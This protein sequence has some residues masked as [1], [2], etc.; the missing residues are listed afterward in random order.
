MS[1]ASRPAASSRVRYPGGAGY[2]G[3]GSGRGCVSVPWRC[4]VRGRRGG[5]RR[6][7]FSSAYLGLVYGSAGEIPWGCRV[8]R[9]WPR[10]PGSAVL[11]W[12]VVRVDV[13]RGRARH[14]D[15][16]L[17][18]KTGQGDGRRARAEPREYSTFT[19][20]FQGIVWGPGRVGRRRRGCRVSTRRV[21]GSELGGRPRRGQGAGAG[22]NRRG[23]TGAGGRCVG[24]AM[25]FLGTFGADAFGGCERIFR[26]GRSKVARFGKKV[27]GEAAAARGPH[28]QRRRT[29]EKGEGE[30]QSPDQSTISER[31]ALVLGARGSQASSLASRRA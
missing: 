7:E 13:G 28:K 14:Q 24:A 9:R 6:G 17:L 2:A 29:Y 3:T 22:K 11:V 8:P 1:R 4:R 12:C 31:T 20:A 21:P 25:S 23:V 18:G 27:S 19:A 26:G 16:A 15:A 30:I 5:P 10:S